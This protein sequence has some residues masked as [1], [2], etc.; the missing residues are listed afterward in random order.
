MLRLAAYLRGEI[1]QVLRP[2][3]RFPRGSQFLQ[4]VRWTVQLRRVMVQI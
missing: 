3:M 2:R 4:T 1:G